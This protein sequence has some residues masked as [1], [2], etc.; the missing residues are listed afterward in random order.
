M[1]SLQ[2]IVPSL[3]RG[4]PV[5]SAVLSMGALPTITESSE[6]HI[7]ANGSDQADIHPHSHLRNR[8]IATDLRYRNRG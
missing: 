2:L 3:L 5:V 6:I 4:L 8:G 1:P 7:T